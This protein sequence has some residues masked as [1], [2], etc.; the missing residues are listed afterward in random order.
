[1]F[2]IPRRLFFKIQY[3][4]LRPGEPLE[5]AQL[6]HFSDEDMPLTSLDD[7]EWVTNILEPEQQ[8]GPSEN[9]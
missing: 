5:S 3:P 7:I 8:R 2:K 4:T 9:P 6:G 1:M